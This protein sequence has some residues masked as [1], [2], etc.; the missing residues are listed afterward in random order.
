MQLIGQSGKILVGAIFKGLR[1]NILSTSDFPDDCLVRKTKFELVQIGEHYCFLLYP[2]ILCRLGPKSMK[3]RIW[4][5]PNSQQIL[6]LIF[7]ALMSFAV[8]EL[9]VEFSRISWGSP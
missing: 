8:S 9:G 4:E 1:P 2:C 5:Y 7:I 6:F 3:S